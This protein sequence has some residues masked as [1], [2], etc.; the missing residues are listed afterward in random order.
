MSF[1]NEDK[2]IDEISELR[3]KLELAEAQLKEAREQKP[4]GRFVEI[5]DPIN[6]T[7]RYDVEWYPGWKVGELL[8]KTA[9]LVVV[10][11]LGA[12]LFRYQRAL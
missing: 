1:F 11:V 6:R 9:A 2:L 4:Y 12:E 8:D 10:A 3:E 7:T 5:K